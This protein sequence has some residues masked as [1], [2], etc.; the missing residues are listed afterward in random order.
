MKVYD[1]R[2]TDGDDLIQKKAYVVLFADPDSRKTG[3]IE[4]SPSKLSEKT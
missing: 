1:D 3:L 4:E 2:V